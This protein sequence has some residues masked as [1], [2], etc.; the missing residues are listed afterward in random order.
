MSGAI[1]VDAHGGPEVLEWT[2][3]DPGEPG[4]GEVLVAHTA[5]GLNFIDVYQRTGLYKNPLPVPLGLEGAG[6]VEAVGGGVTTVR[7]VGVFAPAR[8]PDWT[9]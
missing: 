2:T 3:R 9:A 6:T 1:V 4:P 5:I 8:T 7:P